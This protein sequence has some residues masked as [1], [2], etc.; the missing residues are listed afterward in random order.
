MY[1]APAV[2]PTPNNLVVVQATSVDNPNSTMIVN[3]QVLNPVPILL[4]ATP[5]SLNIGSSTVV[6][7]GASFINGATV[8]ANGAP[9][10]TQFNSSGQ[11]TATV[12]PTVAGPFDLQVLNPNPG[13]A[14]SADVVEQVAGTPPTPLVDPPDASRFLMQATF[15]GSEADINHLSTIGYNAWFAEQFAI[16]NT[17]HEPYAEREVILNNHPPCAATDARLQP[18]AIPGDVRR[19]IFRAAFLDHRAH[20]QRRVAEARSVRAQRIVRN[21]QP[22]LRS[23][24]KC[25]AESPTTTTCW[26]TMP[27][28]TSASC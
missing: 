17:L 24:G 23:L 12:D 1:T 21:L 22:G 25:H 7:T 10:P 8:L 19:S 9:I 11:L 16:P 20:R 13:G 4:S 3:V 15:G 6:L 18:E 28:A 2:V 26:A 14:V 5:T 27:S